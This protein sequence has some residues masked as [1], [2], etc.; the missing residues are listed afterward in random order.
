MRRILRWTGVGFGS[1]AGL[2]LLAATGLYV[3]SERILDR[4]YDVPLRPFA[5]PTDSAAIVEGQRL[6]TMYGCYDGCHGKGFD[7]G[8]FWDEPGIAHIVAPNLTR[9]ARTH[10]D[11]EL[12]RVIR[13]GVRKDG[14]STFAMPSAS[15]HSLTDADLGAILAF[16]RSV[17]PTDG[18]EA[19]LRAGPMGRLGLVLGEFPPQ[20]ADIDHA[21]ARNP[22]PAAR[23]P[24]ARGRY[25][26]VTLC[27][28]CHGLDLRGI[29]GDNP[30]LVAAAAY[31]PED[32][33]RLMRTG[34]P[35][36]GRDLIL[37]DD[38]ARQRFVHLT[39]DELAAL[40]AYLRTLPDVRRAE[41][42]AQE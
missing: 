29:P 9:T 12:E 38:M 14:R 25:L 40:H 11:A 4:T 42:G 3:Q 22:N 39:D 13:H 8:V 5:A 26:A 33:E 30:D 19:V 37:M 28:E 35:L 20:V 17:P 1:F 18:P 6:A 24:E 36:G 21:A 23:G 10:T 41:G 2:A 32:F 15:F 34:V 16:L 27:S 31:A 7:G